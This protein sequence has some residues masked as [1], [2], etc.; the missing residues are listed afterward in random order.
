M[1][2]LSVGPP[3]EYQKMFDITG[4]SITNINAIGYNIKDNFIYG[5]GTI[6][7][8]P[9]LVRIDADGVANEFGVTLNGNSFSA[10]SVVGDFDDKGDLWITSFVSGSSKS[11]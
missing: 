8:T 5:I 11:L 9:K 10:N 1:K 2:R 7:G 3:S 4:N 6:N